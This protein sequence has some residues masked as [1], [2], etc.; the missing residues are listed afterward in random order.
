MSSRMVHVPKLIVE[1]I[2]KKTLVFLFIICFHSTQ[3]LYAQGSTPNYPSSDVSDSTTIIF[4]KPQYLKFAIFPFLYSS[5]FRNE[6]WLIVHYEI[7]VKKTPISISGVVEYDSWT[8]LQSIGTSS[9]FSASGNFNLW[10]RPQIRYYLSKQTLSGFYSGVFPVVLYRDI[11]GPQRLNGYYAGAGLTFGYQL[12]FRSR[13]PVDFNLRISK[14]NGYV[15]S[16]DINGAPSMIHDSLLF[17]FMEIN[18][19]LRTR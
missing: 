11:L 2:N 14:Q 18:I 16:I 10:L 4:R 3:W 8:H 9:F 1:Q 19:G 7:G 17:G 12:L 13:Y 5:I 15:K 6:Q